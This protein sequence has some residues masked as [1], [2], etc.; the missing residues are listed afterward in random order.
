MARPRLAQLDPQRVA[1]ERLQALDLP[2]VVELAA[3]H[4][5][6]VEL[7]QADDSLVLERRQAGALELGVV[8]ALE[9][10]DEVLG[11]ELARLAL[12]GRIV[13]EEDARPDLE[14][15]G[16]EVLRDLGHRLGGERLQLERPGQVVV[17]EQRV[18]DVRGAD[19]RVDVADLGRIES[20]LGDLE[21]V[22]QHLFAGARVAGRAD[23]R[24][25][26][27]RARPGRA[28][29]AQAAAIACVTSRRFIVRSSSR[30]PGGERRSLGARLRSRRLP[31][32]SPTLADTPTDGRLPHP[33]PVADDPHRGGRRPPGFPAVQ[34]LRR[35]P[36][37]KSWP[38]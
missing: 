37:A 36:G 38:A 19:A 31:R 4:R 28:C 18:E 27:G 14:G 9:G 22:A 12:E 26:T 30:N 25:A 8:D 17:G 20:G 3:L 21:G 35:R 1:V 7:A 34:V 23:R 5:L 6:G 29:I 15:E 2:V 10:V 24:P 16:P 32:P 11:D 13:G 33:P